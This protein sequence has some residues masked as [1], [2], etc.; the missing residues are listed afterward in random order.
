MQNSTLGIPIR[1]GSLSL[2]LSAFF[3][4]V[5]VAAAFA[6]GY[7]FNRGRTEAMRE[8]GLA[9]LR[10]HA[11]RGADEL[12]R[13][14]RQLGRDVLFLAGTPP[15]EGIGS[16][17]DGSGLDRIGRS[18]ARQWKEQL[19]QIFLAFAKARSQYLQLRLI[20]VADKGRELVRVERAANGQARAVTEDALQAKGERDYFREAARL[21]PG[22]VYLSRI[23]LNREHGQI[24]LPHQPTLRA[25]TPVRDPSGNLFGLVAVNMDMAAVFARVLAF[26][27]PAESLF[28]ANEHGDF[29]LH[30]EPG[31]AFAFELGTAYRLADAFPGAQER[32]SNALTGSSPFVQLPGPDGE[33]VAYVTERAWDPRDSARRLIFILT[34]LADRATGLAGAWSRERLLATPALLLLAMGLVVLGVQ[35]LTRSLRAIARASQAIA[36]GNYRAVLPAGGGSEVTGLVRAFRHMAT[37]IETR[38]AE[39]GALNQGLEQ[40]VKERTAEL[41]RAHSWQKTILDNIADGV[42]V[43]DCVGRFLLWNPKAEQII[44]AGP[45]Q[46]A[47]ERWSSHYGLFWEEAGTPIPTA[48]LPLVRAMQGQCSES[49][50]MY[51]RNPHCKAGR[52]IQVTARPLPD[53]TG[54]INGGVAILV[55]VTDQKRLR[56]RL[57]SERAQL[58]ELAPL[59]LGAAIATSAVHRLS[60]PIAAMNNYAGAVVRLHEQQRLTE[61]E[62]RDLL[63]RIETCAARAGEGLDELRNLIRQRNHPAVPVNLNQVVD[64]SLQFLR[65]RIERLGVTVDRR[66]GTA[67][68]Q[69]MGDPIELSHVVIQLISSALEALA[70]MEPAQRRLSAGTSHDPQAGVVLIEVADSWRSLDPE[71]E[72][73]LFDPLPAERPGAKGFGLYI[74]KTIVDN[75]K[76]GIFIKRG[77]TGGVL[78]VIELPIAREGTA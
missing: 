8:L 48:D 77:E 26:K 46:V 44:G 32:L 66:Y 64:S 35:R 73:Q 29:L 9:R 50:E 55:D 41:A 5:L 59:A 7:L 18:D 27:D 51:V 37:E 1:W 15:V 28:L 62:L 54:K 20:G 4:V 10:L 34:E 30:P 58:M 57:E 56:K 38:E 42:V 16:A 52:W 25:V 70:D 76:G 75:H 71:L 72:R 6:F 61:A 3:V 65:H 33:V 19:Q 40:R 39:L 47:P 43:V 13:S 60:Q 45:D 63:A 2:R 24:S 22:Q 21:E 53:T 12:E 74:A 69:S 31:R 14:V 49:I 67:L 23:D 36:A 68:P 11:E 17:L 78:F